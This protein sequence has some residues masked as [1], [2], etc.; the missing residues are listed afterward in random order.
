MPRIDTS[1]DPGHTGGRESWQKISTTQQDPVVDSNHVGYTATDTDDWPDPPPTKTQE[2]IDMLADSR[3]EAHTLLDGSV[4]TDTLAGT[5]TRGD[6][7]V[8]NSTPKWSRLAVGSAN[9]LIASDGTD[10]GWVSDVTIAGNLTVTGTLDMT[11]GAIVNAT[12]IQAS[13]LITGASYLA[14]TGIASFTNATDS[15]VENLL[16]FRARSG[17][18]TVQSGD[19]LAEMAIY[20]YD[21]A[22]Y[23]KSG[24]IQITAN[25]NWSAAN[26]GTTITFQATPEADADNLVDLMVMR[27][28]DSSVYTTEPVV[29]IHAD[30]VH[31]V[32][33]YMLGMKCWGSTA[34]SQWPVAGFQFARGT[35]ASPS[36]IQ[37]G[38]WLGEFQFA[39]YYNGSY[40]GGASFRAW[41]NETWATGQYGSAFYIYTVPQGSATQ[42][43]I[44]KLTAGTS[45]DG[46][47]SVL[48]DL[49]V[50]GTVYEEST[51][52]AVLSFSATAGA[53][54]YTQAS[55]AT[56]GNAPA[57]SAVGSDSNIDLEFSAKGTGELALNSDTRLTGDLYV[58]S[59]MTLT[60]IGSNTAS[61]HA[62]AEMRR[63]RGTIGSPSAVQDD[64]YLGEV[65]YF[66]Y[67][68]TG[69][70]EAGSV[71]GVADENWSG[72]QNGGRLEFSVTNQGATTV[73]KEMTLSGNALTMHTGGVDVALGWSTGGQMD[74][75]VGATT[76]MYL[77]ANG[78]DVTDRVRGANLAADSALTSGVAGLF[79]IDSSIDVAGSTAPPA[80]SNLPT[81]CI[82]IQLGWKREFSGTTKGWT[83]FY[84]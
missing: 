22:A 21:D 26:Q 6:L 1:S 56:T 78:L 72:S 12:T 69:Y 62:A 82:G 27:C 14:S 51:A 25:E 58:D 17:P 35:K 73:T 54:N 53:V 33:Q 80:M 57:L 46:T 52:T 71:R 63:A 18:A 74:F 20:G 39:G 81:G 49:H 2:A 50:S 47:M 29:A 83:P 79:I 55:N 59:G 75:K 5:V 34:A 68:G 28:A 41:A 45:D 66:G 67:N 40:Y 3:V 24:S 31:V 30:N 11:S 15:D 7:I 38:D 48:G 84:V 10:I 76:E 4:H 64:D 9:Q 32:S 61:D 16:L 43:P 19:V 8:G 37:S 23:T 36:G 44:V 70:V 77:D 13:S 42:F 65:Q 60:T